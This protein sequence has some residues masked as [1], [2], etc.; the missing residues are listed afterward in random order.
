M[1]LAKEPGMK[2]VAAIQALGKKW[3]LLKK[4]LMGAEEKKAGGKRWE[5]I[6]LR[7]EGLGALEAKGRWAERMARMLIGGCCGQWR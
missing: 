3:W 7:E 6:G 1:T 5:G 2:E 4:G